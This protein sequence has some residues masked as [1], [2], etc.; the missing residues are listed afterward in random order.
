MKLHNLVP[1]SYI[2]VS[3]SD[4]QYIF[5]G[6][7]FLFGSSEIGIPILGIYEIAHRYMN[8]KT[9]R[10]NIVILFWK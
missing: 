3:V 2:H 5:P 4:L 1:N 9:R 7:V 6:L 10:Q 8:V